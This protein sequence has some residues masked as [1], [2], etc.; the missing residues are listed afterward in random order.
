LFLS[1]PPGIDRDMRGK[2]VEAIADIDRDTYEETGDP[3]TAARISQYELAHR[4]QMSA[5]D[6]MDFAKEPEHI[7]QLYGTRPGQES[8][9]NNCIR[10][11]RLIERGVRFVQ[12]FDWGWDSHGT[13]N[14]TSL[15][16]GFADK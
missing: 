5:T 10:A 3:E 1:N 11:R 8:L 2:V 12:L 4:M 14:D 7:H 15:N 9:A 13:S 16:F 6:A